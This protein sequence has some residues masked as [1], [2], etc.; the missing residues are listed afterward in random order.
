MDFKSCDYDCGAYSGIA[1]D[2][3]PC[4]ER[5]SLVRALRDALAVAIGGKCGSHARVVEYLAQRSPKSA[6]MLSDAAEDI[7]AFIAFPEAGMAVD[8]AQ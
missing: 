3:I 6:V 1:G 5:R 4:V 7:L 8:L 2:H